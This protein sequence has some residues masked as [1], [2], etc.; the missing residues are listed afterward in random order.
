MARKK[1][2][3]L[4]LFPELVS[5]TRKF[6]DEQF[7]ILMRAAFS[8]RFTGEVYDGEDMA[9]EVAFQ[10]VANQIDRYTEFCEKQSNNAKNTK[11]MPEET[12]CIQEQPSAAKCS[13]TEPEDAEESKMQQNTP[14]IQSISNP[15]P[16]QSNPI[17]SRM[18]M[19]DEPPISP[20]KKREERHKYGEYKNVLLS[21]EE[22]EK[23][24]KE[25]PDW[26]NM[27][28]RLSEYIASSGKKYK[29]H[30]ATLR[31]WNRREPK[32]NKPP[33][34]YPEDDLSGIL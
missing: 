32:S 12:S 13:Q 22:L 27:V 25:L 16:I 18:D 15:C 19:A 21:D 30:Y 5:I 20:P 1:Q 7:G 4:V 10:T 28:E 23:L 33:Q 34:V 24:Q 26:Q 3:T 14:P 8:Y 11:D 6:T 31:S 2:E 17:Q 29:S 9:I